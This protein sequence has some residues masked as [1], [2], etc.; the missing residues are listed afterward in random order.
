MKMGYF[1]KPKDIIYVFLLILVGYILWSFQTVHDP[2]VSSDKCWKYKK[3][4]YFFCFVQ[5]GD[6]Y[7]NIDL[8]SFITLVKTEPKKIGLSQE[9][10]DELKLIYSQSK[11]NSKANILELSVPITIRVSTLTYQEP[12]LDK[13][14]DIVCENLEAWSRDP[15]FNPCEIDYGLTL[16]AQKVVIITWGIEY[17]QR[18]LPF[19]SA[20]HAIFSRGKLQ[21]IFGN[22]IKTSTAINSLGKPEGNLNA[23]S[24]KP[25]CIEVATYNQTELLIDCD[26]QRQLNY[27]NK[28][29]LVLVD[30][31][32]PT[33]YEVLFAYERIAS[34][35]SVKSNLALPPS[36]TVWIDASEPGN[37]LNMVSNIDE[38]SSR[39]KETYIFPISPLHPFPGKNQ[40]NENNLKKLPISVTK[41]QSN[42][43]LEKEGKIQ[44]VNYCS[45]K[46]KYC[47]RPVLENDAREFKSISLDDFNRTSPFDCSDNSVGLRQINAYYHLERLID[48]YDSSGL[49][50]NIRLPIFSLLV[51]NTESSVG[52]YRNGLPFVLLGGPTKCKN[53]EIVPYNIF[54]HSLDSS[55]IAHEAS[56]SI[57]KHLQFLR[58]K[59]WCLLENCPSPGIS[60]SYFHDFA[61]VIATLYVSDNCIGLWVAK[62][63]PDSTCLRFLNSENFNF[64]NMLE[65]RDSYKDNHMKGAIPATALW[66]MN[67]TARYRPNLETRALIWPIVLRS[68]YQFGWAKSINQECSV[69][70][71]KQNCQQ[72]SAL[73]PLL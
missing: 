32:D 15:T 13:L 17:E 18:F 22:P 26:S 41:L 67:S 7:R 38:F 19:P 25:N 52:G 16:D 43:I 44:R 23:S 50:E 12:D 34:S 39:R 10:I 65:D 58:P 61:D 35:K 11:G 31:E 6:D 55:F 69:V 14:Y 57:V 68:F 4:T 33:K 1:N 66:E 73:I 64:F 27:R 51:D 24:L 53:K 47:D 56:H 60:S 42:Y 9:N 63:E 59:N 62:S 70:A 37:V 3:G 8:E 30:N 71:G 5:D 28:S 2:I 21:S 46:D 20:I 45:N 54:F 36:Y 40:A 72:Y 49:P 29:N 48:I